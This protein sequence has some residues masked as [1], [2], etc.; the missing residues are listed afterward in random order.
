LCQRLRKLNPQITI[1]FYSADAGQSDDQKGLAAGANAYL[2][3]PFVIILRWLSS[4]LWL[5]RQKLSENWQV[6]D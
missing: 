4:N 6:N 3:K 1:V 2:V 5:L